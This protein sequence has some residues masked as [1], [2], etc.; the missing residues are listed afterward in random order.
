[1]FSEFCYTQSLFCFFNGMEHLKNVEYRLA[2]EAAR[3]E[4]VFGRADDCGTLL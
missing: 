3:E 1:M 2:S 4:H